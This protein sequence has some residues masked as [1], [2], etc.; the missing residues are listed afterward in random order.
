MKTIVL[1]ALLMGTTLTSFAQTDSSAGKSDTIRIGGM[2]IVKKPG[3]DGGESKDVVISSRRR[4]RLTNV[5]T[6]WW[7]V[8]LGFANYKDETNYTSAQQSGFVTS[9]ISGKDNLKLRTGKSVNVNIWVFM[10]KLNLAKHVVNLKYGLGVELNNYRFDDERVRF[11]KNPTTVGID[12]ALA[13]ADKNKLAADYVTVPVML[14]FNF[15]PGRSR[16]FGLSAGVSAG[17]LYSARQKIKMDGDKDKL[18]DDF[19]LEKWKLSYIAEL[20]LGPVRLYG[21]MAMKNMWEKGLDQT[22]YNVGIRFSHF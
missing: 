6:N 18:K 3:K 4:N 8:D 15:T 21:S 22:P 16:G 12:P 17:Y 7:I 19:N 20:S 11:T 10:Q 13:T 2:I 1:V 9:G 5:S 14:N